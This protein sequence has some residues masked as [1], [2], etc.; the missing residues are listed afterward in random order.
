MFHFDMSTAK[1]L[2]EDAPRKIDK[3]GYL[4]PYRFEGADS[5]SDASAG[6]VTGRVLVK[7]GVNISTQTRTIESWEVALES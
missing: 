3:K 7:V 6:S 1:H 4:I 5:A 2:D